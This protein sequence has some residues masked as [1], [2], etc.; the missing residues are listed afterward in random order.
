[1][2]YGD[3]SA[4]GVWHAVRHVG[5]KDAPLVPSPSAAGR[6][7]GVA[8][9]VLWSIGRRATHIPSTGVR[10]E[11][12]GDP[13]ARSAVPTERGGLHGGRDGGTAPAPPP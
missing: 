12:A 8:Q 13:R 2:R 7:T 9:W 11:V 4:S 10:A 1:M 5:P 3:F 6:S